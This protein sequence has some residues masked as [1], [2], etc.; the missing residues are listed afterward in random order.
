[1][2]PES[3]FPSQVV[4]LSLSSTGSLSAWFRI[5]YPNLVAGAV[6]TSAPVEAKLNFVEYLEVVRDSLAT[7]KQG[8]DC[9]NAVSEA[10]IQLTAL[11]KD[12]SS[13]PQVEKL[14]K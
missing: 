8:E 6:A 4:S 3:L 10:N 5:K 14:F 7:S 12:K 2:V 1:M 9:V 11:L 13:W